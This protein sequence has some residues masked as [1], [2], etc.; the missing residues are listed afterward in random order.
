VDVLPY[1]KD[2]QPVALVGEM[3]LPKVVE[4]CYLQGNALAQNIP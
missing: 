2:K 4:S 1:Q 3:M